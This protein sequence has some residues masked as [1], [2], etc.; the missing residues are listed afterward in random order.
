MSY[1]YHNLIARVR[2]MRHWTGSVNGPQHTCQ[3]AD[4]EAI[5]QVCALATERANQL[6][7]PKQ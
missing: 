5:R 7:R 3:C 1:T 6:L 4:C 2:E